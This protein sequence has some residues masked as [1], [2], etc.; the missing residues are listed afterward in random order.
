MPAPPSPATWKRPRIKRTTEQFQAPGGDLYL[1]RPSETSDIRI[2]DPSPQLRQLLGA[3]DGTRTRRELDEEFGVDLVGELIGQLD[4]M[5]LGED[6]SDDD[7]I[8]PH[9]RARFDRQLRYFSDA[10][11][12]QTPSQ[13]QRKL[14]D[15]RIAVLGVGGLGGWSALTLA[16]CGIGEMLLVDF[17]T[18]ELS[19]LNRQILYGE[20]D[21]GQ[22]KAGLAAK[23]LGAFNSS[24]Q[25]ETREER[26][27]SEA[28]VAAAIEGCD[29]VVSAVDWPAHDIELWV[30]SACFA[31]G[32]PYISM[33]HYPP[34]ARVGPLYVP[35]ETGCYSCQEIAYKR[36]YPLYD[37]VVEQQ[38][39]KPSPAATLGAACALI[40]GQVA[41]DVMHFLTG[42]A[43]P[44]SLGVSNIYDLRTMEAK[45][46]QV[47]Q[48]PDCPVC[49]ARR[50]SQSAS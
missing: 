20:A 41:L 43:T 29:L 12:G 10:S 34:I 21:I 48:E 33:S 3:L 5:G 17:D 32:I 47:V 23:R 26:L 39:A 9:T 44:S 42:L 18:V 1:R 37:P 22:P 19:N 40:S 30:N 15:A 50:V 45:R 13:C 28:A 46:E 31:A 4:E 2:K 36:S 27:D 24:V 25:I 7:L 35:G 38:R 8:D 49:S 11:T 14:E 6:A 16:C